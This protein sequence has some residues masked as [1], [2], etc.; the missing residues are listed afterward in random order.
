[1]VVSINRCSSEPTAPDDT[2]ALESRGTRSCSVRARNIILTLVET[3]AADS[4]KKLILP[5]NTSAAAKQSK[6][7]KADVLSNI[8]CNGRKKR[9]RFVGFVLYT[10]K[11]YDKRHAQGTSPP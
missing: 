7:S 11:Q 10:Q 6:A 9:R 2:T 4:E 5:I 1:M 3:A 8:F